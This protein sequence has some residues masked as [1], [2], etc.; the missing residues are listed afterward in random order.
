ME[1]DTV[2]RPVDARAAVRLP[3]AFAPWAFVTGAA[4]GKR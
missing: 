4:A 3:D 2:P 1:R